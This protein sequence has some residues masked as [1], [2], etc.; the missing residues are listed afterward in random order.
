MASPTKSTG[1]DTTRDLAGIHEYADK[2]AVRYLVSML[3][4]LSTAVGVLHGVQQVVTSLK[5]HQ[6][7]PDGKLGGKGYVLSIRK[8]KDTISATVN[9][10][11]DLTD[12]LSDELTN[13]RWKLSEEELR[14]Y[15]SYKDE[16]QDAAES[17]TEQS[18]SQAQ[19]PEVDST[20]ETIAPVLDTNESEQ[21]PESLPEP[22]PETTEPEFNS[23]DDEPGLM[24]GNNEDSSN[25]QP[26]PFVKRASAYHD[27]VQ[28]AMQ[29]ALYKQYIKTALRSSG[30]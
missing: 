20:D 17:K 24:D 12:T 26:L 5:G 8:F 29:P 11:S 16:L 21:A 14:Q 9:D 25:L 13:P 27:P 4:N 18:I 30:Q 6:I 2:G 1:S 19:L 15:I 23:E 3:N 28:E 10:L 7:S 22:T